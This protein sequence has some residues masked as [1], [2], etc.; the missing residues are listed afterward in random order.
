MDPEIGPRELQ[1]KVHF[2]LR[3]YFARR[4]AENIYDFTKTTFKYIVDKENGVNYIT[5]AEDEATKNHEESDNEIISGYMPELTGSKNCPVQSYMT[6]LIS[7]DPKCDYFWQ[8]PR[9]KYFPKDGKGIWY[10]P[11]RVGHNPT[12]GFI[13]SLSKNC[14]FQDKKY[15][16]HSL[17]ITAINGLT[18]KEFT[19]R[20]WP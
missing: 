6:Y 4:G 17:R 7:L 20:S 10:G 19:N 18:H 13:T 16:N 12:D 3:Y 8:K 11:E 1:A 14:G 2:D 15:T 9:M 5:R